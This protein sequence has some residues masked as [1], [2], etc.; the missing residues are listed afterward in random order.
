MI[1]DELT[2]SR[3]S[4]IGHAHR[5]LQ[6]I[7]TAAYGPGEVAVFGVGGGFLE[8]TEV[9][10]AFVILFFAAIATIWAFGAVTAIVC[11]AMP[12]RAMLV[13]CLLRC[14]VIVQ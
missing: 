2:W 9:V 7:K 14:C 5:H 6:S 13:Y 3:H 10:F 12:V 1:A 8:G 11:S 4:G